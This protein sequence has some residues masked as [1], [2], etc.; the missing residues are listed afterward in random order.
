MGTIIAAL[1]KEP[2]VILGAIAAAILAI[3]QSL[4][5]N[6]ILSGDVVQWVTNAL[7]P[8]HGW[9]IPLVVTII[10]RFLVV[11]PA[12]NAT[13]VAAALNTPVPD[14]PSEG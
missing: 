5:G 1:E 11:S 7:D 10:G 2:L 4:A 14:Q 8:S 3:V 6:G 12:T 13:Q 9:L